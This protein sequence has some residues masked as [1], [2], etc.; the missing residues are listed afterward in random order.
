[1]HPMVGIFLEDISISMLNQPLESNLLAKNGLLKRIN[2]LDHENEVHK[3]PEMKINV[4][5]FFINISQIM[6]I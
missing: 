1:M 5:I 3:I 4:L 2:S 6:M